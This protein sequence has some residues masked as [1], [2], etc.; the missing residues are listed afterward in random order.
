M[1]HVVAVDPQSIGDLEPESIAL[2]SP[3]RESSDRCCAG[4]TEQVTFSSRAFRRFGYLSNQSG[5][6]T[7]RHERFEHAFKI[8]QPMQ[9]HC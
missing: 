7:K 2:A 3:I 1:A 5:L 4:A 6:R 8:D 9:Q